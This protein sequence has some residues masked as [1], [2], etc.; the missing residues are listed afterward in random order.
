M[1][2]LRFDVAEQRDLLAVFA[3]QRPLG[4][5]DQNVGLNTDLPQLA[6]AV[7]RRLGLGLAGRLQVRHQRQ[8]DEQAILLADV[9]RNLADRLEERQ[10]LDV[11]HRAA[12]FGDHHVDVRPV[13]VEDG[14]LDLVG[15]VRDHL[16]GPAEILASPFFFDHRR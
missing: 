4:S 2:A 12:E 11:A 1:T 16:D 5:H 3:S 14:R 15:D 6:D 10:P 7:L 13:E 8:V 9:E